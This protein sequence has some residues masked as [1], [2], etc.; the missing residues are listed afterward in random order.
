MLGLDSTVPDATGAFN[1]A[2]SPLREGLRSCCGPG[3]PL[4]KL[5]IRDAPPTDGRNT[6]RVSGVDR[7]HPTV[8]RSLRAALG[9]IGIGFA[10]STAA[11]VALLAV[12]PPT[13]LPVVL[14]APAAGVVYVAAGLF[15]WWRR[16]SNRLAVVLVAGGGVW[17]LTG[18]VNVGV[19]ALAVAGVVTA[20]VPLAVVVHLVLAFPTGRLR[21]RLS[22]STVL[23]GYGVCLLLQAPLYLL[24]PAAGPAGMLT[25]S[26]RPR[27]LTAGVWAQR[28]AGLAV[29]GVTVWVLL[30]RLRA[31]TARQRRVL[32]PLYAYGLVGLVA[33]PL[34]PTA[35][36]PVA[37]MT[38]ALTAGVQVAL[39][40]VAPAAFVAAA[41]RGGFARTGELAELGTW[42]GT[43]VPGRPDLTSALAHALGDETVRLLYRT[44]EGGYVDEGGHAAAL[45]GPG[46]GRDVVPVRFQSRHIGAITFDATMTGETTLAREAAQVVAIAVEQQRLQVELRRSRARILQAANEER[47]RIAQDLHDGIQVDLVLLALQAQR[48]A[49]RSGTPPSVAADAVA[50]RTRIDEAAAALRR[51]AQT[52]M[53]AALVERGLAGATEDLIDRIPVPTRLEF[54]VPGPLPT[55][56]SN[57]AYFILAEALGNAVKHAG[58]SALTVRLSRA[59]HTLTLAV[60]DNGVGG[61]R[62][63]DGL[64]LPGLADRVDALGGR[65]RIDS[66][67]GHGTHILVELPC[68]S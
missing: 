44:P 62:P 56:V 24:G 25:L 9:M 3:G 65:L 64:G 57:T 22:R 14:L 54:D 52:V 39:L 29:V 58:A 8:G 17:L 30:R 43:G 26:D 45:P 49:T 6:V 60:D 1:G 53:P 16:P 59:D 66:P 28:G 50:L 5:P 38:P 55:L 2:E 21:S 4:R 32:G 33:T 40:A 37:G 41:G 20:T 18:L 23:A 35:L 11:E 63:A 36:A 7:W 10:A 13:T 12:N 42:L 61:A 67:A 48:L 51:L 19:P 68:V 15:A 31:A 47:R 46:A 34:V 27:L